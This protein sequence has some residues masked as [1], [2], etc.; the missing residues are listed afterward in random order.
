M[1]HWNS[2]GQKNLGQERGYILYSHAG[3]GDPAVEGNIW[4]DEVMQGSRN[5]LLPFGEREHVPGSALLA[6]LCQSESPLLS[7]TLRRQNVMISMD[8]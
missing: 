8:T 1:S 5:H 2:S 3:N 6:L 7:G 4:P